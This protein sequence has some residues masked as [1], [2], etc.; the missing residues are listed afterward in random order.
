MAI[1]KLEIERSDCVRELF[2]K[3]HDEMTLS[4]DH[5]PEEHWMEQNVQYKTELDSFIF[6]CETVEDLI[7]ELS[8]PCFGEPLIASSP[9]FK[10]YE[11]S[12]I[13]ER[14]ISP[15][16]I[17]IPNQTVKPP[18][19]TGGLVSV[20]YNFSDGPCPGL[21]RVA[22]TSEYDSTFRRNN[23]RRTRASCVTSGGRRQRRTVY[24]QSQLDVLEHVFSCNRFLSYQES[25]RLSSLLDICSDKLMTWFQNRRG[26]EKRSA[27]RA[28]Q[29]LDTAVVRGSPTVTA[30]GSYFT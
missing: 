12:S 4:H 21:L 25:V 29:M 17:E 5:F 23:R 20:N 10:Q 18:N 16:S 3:D 19:V 26:R 13:D 11:Y 28:A 6:S 1:P 27:R 15:L 30:P 14:P 9:V 7:P 8:I 2:P 22:N 24:T